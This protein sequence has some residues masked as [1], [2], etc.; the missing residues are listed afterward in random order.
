MSAIPA[1]ATVQ[2][3]PL[4][5]ESNNRRYESLSKK[6]NESYA[7]FRSG[8]PYTTCIKRLGGKITVPKIQPRNITEG[9]D[10]F[11]IAKEEI[12][13]GKFLLLT[14]Q[15]EERPLH[16]LQDKIV[17]EDLPQLKLN[18]LYA[19]EIIQHVKGKIFFSSNFPNRGGKKPRQEQVWKYASTLD[20]LRK[21]PEEVQFYLI[22]EK[23]VGNCHEMALLGY[24]YAQ[25]VIPIKRMEIKGG[26]HE[27]LVIGEGPS[28]VICDPWAD[29]YYPF[30]AAK[31]FLRN[32]LY[33]FECVGSTTYEA[34]ALVEH[35]DEKKH[36]ILVCID[37]QSVRSKL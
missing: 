32:S 5:R 23:H 29:A 18:L 21:Q 9:I 37:K 6:I 19:R 31:M 30:F 10:Q 1:V 3:S 12:R 28:S 24:K 15:T 17:S 22:E 14:G 36:S 4:L 16:S 34:W 2:T 33:R 35:L 20:A 11:R 8:I 25:G 27:F 13:D 26:D 7:F